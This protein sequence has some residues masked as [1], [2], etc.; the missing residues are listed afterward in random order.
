MICEAIKQ[1]F[2]LQKNFSFNCQ[3]VWA[4]NPGFYELGNNSKYEILLCFHFQ[5]T[6]HFRNLHALRS[7]IQDFSLDFQPYKFKY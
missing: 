2:E 6:C 4:Q 3:G 1:M 7:G 5:V